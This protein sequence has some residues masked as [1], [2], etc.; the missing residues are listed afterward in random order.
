MVPRHPAGRKPFRRA[1][2]QAWKRQLRDRLATDP[3]QRVIDPALA[4]LWRAAPQFAVRPSPLF[5]PDRGLLGLSSTTARSR[6]G[7]VPRPSRTQSD[8]NWHLLLCL[9]AEPAYQPPGR[10]RS[11]R[12]RKSPG[13]A[14]RIHD[15]RSRALDRPTISP[16]EGKIGRGTSGNVILRIPARP[17]PE[18]ASH[19]RDL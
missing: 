18:N 10:R 5:S 3:D 16:S 15:Q 6:S 2:L 13:I 4:A 9:P 8:P 17:R 14:L 19:L 1:S 12:S 11:L 7:I